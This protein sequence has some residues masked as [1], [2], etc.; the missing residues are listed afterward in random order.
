MKMITLL[1]SAVLI[2]LVVLPHPAIAAFCRPV[3][4]QQV[5]IVSIQRSAKYY[6]EYRVVLRVNGEEK[7]LEVYNCRDRVRTQSNG[8]RRSFQPDGVGEM[9]CRAFR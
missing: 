9:V 7:P 3:N 2:S 6:W 5:C 4:Q 1:L 8:S